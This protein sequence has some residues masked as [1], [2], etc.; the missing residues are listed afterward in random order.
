MSDIELVTNF[1][2]SNIEKIVGLE[3]KAN[4]SVDEDA[5][6]ELNQAYTKYLEATYNKYSKSKS[7]FIRNQVV[8]LYGYYVP[9]GLS[10]GKL[11]IDDPGFNSCLKNSSRTI[12]VGTGGCGKTILMKHL[13]L[14]CISE[15]DY[16]PVLIELRDINESSNSLEVLIEEVLETYGFDVSS[17]FLEKA[18]A[19][20]HLSF[21][22]DGYDEVDHSLRDKLIKEIKR[23]SNKYPGCPMFI[24]SRPDEVFQGIEDYQVYRM[25][26]LSL[27]SAT[28][29][30]SKLPYDKEVKQKFSKDLEEGLFKS[31]ESFLSNPLLLSI[32]L[33]TYGENAQI[34][35][36][37]SIFYNQAYEALFQRHDAHKGGYSRSRK[38]DLDIL[39]FSRVFS[40]FA[41]QTYEKRLFK[42]PRVDCLKY[43]EKSRDALQKDFQA[44]DYLSDL[45]S[46]ACLLLE[47]GLEI[48]FSHRSF[49]EYFVALH[50][51][52]AAPESQEK[53]IDRY[54]RNMDSDNV[55]NL[56]FE[57]N[58]ELV[59]RV[60]IIPKLTEMFEAI[61][62][63]N[64]VGVTHTAKYL[65]LVYK[66]FIIREDSVSASF[67]SF[68]ANYSSIVRML[69]NEY[70]AFKHVGKH[71]FS[72]F[73]EYLNETYVG[74]AG[75]I[76][77]KIS[78]MTYRTPLM[79]DIINSDGA[80][81]AKYLQA[82]YETFKD[83]KKKHKKIGQNLDALLGI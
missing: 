45:L 64:K 51:A 69:V 81:S 54:W 11:T 40:I 74:G 48:A 18:K 37:L 6:Q 57:I 30:I 14:D 80:F 16:A 52:S 38:T 50:I 73:L 68:E 55:I 78:E 8:D 31:H 66:S 44:E 56:L 7:F 53:L 13:F 43:I 35:S 4:G 61:G 70:G 75:E 76:E 32:M 79:A 67:S 39:D 23:M 10:N 82:I 28:K 21:F 65:K 25:L 19:E 27:E 24:S 9:V 59:E 63:K 60:L 62:V 47:D 58:P 15:G 36:K 5:K 83:I 12:I 41:L 71:Q 34:P 77:F 20:G 42:M 29:L 26:P 46:A 49:Q 3:K 2:D 33:L 17:A 1:M 72:G 22:L